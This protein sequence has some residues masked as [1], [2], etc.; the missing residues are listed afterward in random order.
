M[1]VTLVGMQMPAR[2]QRPGL[3]LSVA[4]HAREGRPAGADI[5][6]KVLNRARPYH[7]LAGAVDGQIVQRLLRA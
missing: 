5:R 7:D 2:R 3:G 1:P 6:A 4:D